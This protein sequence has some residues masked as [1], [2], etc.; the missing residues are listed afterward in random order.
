MIGKAMRIRNLRLYQAVRLLADAIAV[1]CA[2]RLTINVRILLNSLASQHVT[3]REATVWAPSLLVVLALWSA[4]AWRL[5]HYRAPA[6]SGWHKILLS[7][8]EQ[9]ILASIAVVSVTVFDRS[10]GFQVSRAFMLIFFPTSLVTLALARFGTLL[11]CLKTESLSLSPV[12]A[13]LLG[14]RQMAA[15]LLR[16]MSPGGGESIFKG[17][18]VPEGQSAIGVPDTLPVLGTT[19]QLAEVINREQITQ[20]IMLNNSMPH[21][22]VERC[23]MVCKRMGMPMN[24]AFEVATGPARMNLSEFYGFPVLE[25]TPPRFSKSQ[26]LLK[27]EFDLLLAS[28][29]L[30]LVAP[31][32]LIIAAAIKLDSE[33]PVFYR[34]AR[35]GKGGRHFICYKFRSMYAVSNR[36]QVAAANEKTGH[37]FKIKNDPRVTR[38][39]RWLR[40]YSLDELP[41]IFNVLRGDMSLVG[42]RP[43]PAADLEP[44]GMS[45]AFAEWAESRS[46]VQPGITG[47]W[48]VRGRSALPFE[49]MVRLDLEY[50]R[51]WSLLSD[52]KII[53][54]TPALVLKGIGAY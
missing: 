10:V 8:V 50:T 44:D 38:V 41:Q 53:L 12:R 36:V 18:I 24:F 42:P 39:G 9:S 21:T 3:I 31:M 29:S 28:I 6:Q 33:G 27:R 26:E 16:Q 48:Q 45:R 14:D 4:L 5:G 13:A 7:I 32:M 2:W 51:N 15:R 46:R 22:E 11:F 25:V 40:R 23:G 52:I 37:I 20:I 54:E 19:M 1:A 47:L 43:L 34:A 30:I 17:L 35:V 49:E